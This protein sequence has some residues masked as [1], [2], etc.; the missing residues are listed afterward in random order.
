MSTKKDEYAVDQNFLVTT[1]FNALQ[2]VHDLFGYKED[3]RAF[4]L[5]DCRDYYWNIQN[6]TVYFSEEEFEGDEATYSSPIFTYRHLNKYVYTT[7]ELTMVLVDTQCDGNIFL[8]IF[9]NEKKVF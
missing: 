6:D 7:S 9:S 4:P 8:M 2:A 5:E 1:Y 3:W